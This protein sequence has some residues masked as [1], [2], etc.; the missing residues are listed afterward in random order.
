MPSPVP[1][2]E[3]PDAADLTRRLREW[4]VGGEVP[5][6][7]V[8]DLLV[9]ELEGIARRIMGRQ[10]AGHTLQA[11]A[12]LNEFWLRVS[13]TDPGAFQDRHHFLGVAVTT[14]RRIVV[15]HARAKR[16]EKRRPKESR[17][18]LEQV[19]DTLQD[20]SDIDLI[21]LDDLL[22]SLGRIDPE[23]LRLIE[24]RFFGGLSR[25]EAA[26]VMGWSERRVQSEELLAR[27]QLKR[28][29]G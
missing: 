5:R 29:M 25:A 18:E 7:G 26:Q 4:L 16:A 24:L 10:P 27:K 20:K 28:L 9:V 21:E 3:F 22:E 23:A 19:V 17:L 12:L 2:S 13:R 14:M 15:D 8:V 1:R 11:T 6:D